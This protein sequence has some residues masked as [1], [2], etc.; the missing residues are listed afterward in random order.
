[1]L[2]YEGNVLLSILRGLQETSSLVKPSWE[3]GTGTWA[4]GGY[5]LLTSS[6]INPNIVYS[7]THSRF[8]LVTFADVLIMP[9]YEDIRQRLFP[10]AFYLA[11][12]EY[13]SMSIYIFTSP[14]DGMLVHFNVSLQHLLILKLPWGI[15]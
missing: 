1:M 14:L 8:I 3:V 11:R 7:V 15:T 13:L 5:A 12:S 2:T 9:S 6:R 4:N 10:R